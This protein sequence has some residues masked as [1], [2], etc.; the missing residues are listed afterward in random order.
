MEL[1]HDEIKHS[2]FVNIDTI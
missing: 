2:Y 1:F